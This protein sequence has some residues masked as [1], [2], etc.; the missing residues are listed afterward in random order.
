MKPKIVIIEDEQD[1]LELLEYQLSK[2]YEV[3]GFL[4]TKRVKD[5]IDEE[6]TDLLIVDRNL[7]GVEGS[8]FVQQ[9]KE[10]GYDIPVIFLTAKDSESD[11]EEGFEKGADD[12][13]TKPFNINELK[14][15]IK[16]ILRRT[17][18]E[19]KEKLIFKDIEIYPQK[20]EVYIA[21]KRV[22]LTNLEFRLLLEFIKN[23]CHVLSRDYLLEHVWGDMKQER[24]V[25]VA[26]KRLKE[27]IDPNREKNYIESIRGVGYKLC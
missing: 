7:P 13:I 11:I 23:R 27:K 21:G 10:E 20:S 24:S 9:L 25:N 1:L 2:E 15:R 17:K 26:I 4:H 16:A 22:N 8:E 19:I 14:L 3:I 12:Y 6:G 18:P 5:F